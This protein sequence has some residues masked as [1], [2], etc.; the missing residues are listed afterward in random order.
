MD[1][2]DEMRRVL[3]WGKSVARSLLLGESAKYFV[4][5][6]AD[7]AKRQEQAIC[8]LQP[9]AIVHIDCDL[10]ASARDALEL[11]SPKLQQGTVLLFDDYNC[12]SADPNQGER[13]A[14]R[15]FLASHPDIEVESWFSYLFAGQAFLVHK[16]GLE[17]TKLSD[18]E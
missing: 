10:Y 14:L 16:I 5:T 6:F 11:V 17:K 9:A 12:F 1:L 13:R 4:G 2:G 7:I 3:R 8:A 15:E 18:R